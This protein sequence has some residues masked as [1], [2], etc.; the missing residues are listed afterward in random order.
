[1]LKNRN[2]MILMIIG[3]AAISQRASDCDSG[4][5][6]SSAFAP[7]SRRMPIGGVVI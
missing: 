1:V 6:Y 4:S 3:Y 7:I 5:S 2:A